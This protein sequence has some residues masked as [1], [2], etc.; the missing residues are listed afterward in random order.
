MRVQL[1]MI[2]GRLEELRRQVAALSRAGEDD[3]HGRRVGKHMEEGPLGPDRD[4]CYR[5][6]PSRGGCRSR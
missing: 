1:V 5:C 3:G 6:G 4:P 2:N